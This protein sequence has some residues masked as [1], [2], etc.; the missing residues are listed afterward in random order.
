[1]TFTAAEIVKELRYEL[2]MRKRVYTRQVEAG[3]MTAEGARRR[4]GMIKQV[5]DRYELEA[6]EASKPASDPL[7]ELGLF[8]D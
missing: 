3:K 8:G 6:N 2:M 5:L 7:E 1:M 4:S